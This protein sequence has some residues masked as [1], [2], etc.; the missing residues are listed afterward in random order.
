MLPYVFASDVVIV[1][2]NIIA[3]VIVVAVLVV[4]AVVVVFVVD[5]AVRVAFFLLM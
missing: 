5:G 2:A 4:V 1:V 3:V